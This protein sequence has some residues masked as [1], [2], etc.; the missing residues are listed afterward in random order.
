VAWIP[1]QIGGDTHGDELDKNAARAFF[2]FAKIW[3]PK[4]R[5]HLGDAFNLVAL[6]K[7]AGDDERRVSIA[8]DFEAGK[9]FLEEFQPTAFLLGNHDVRFHRIAEEDNGMLSDKATDCI[10]EIEA[11]CAKMKCRI[12]PYDV[13]DGVFELGQL[14]VIHGFHHGLH[15]ARQAALVYGAVLQGHVHAIQQYSLESR[16]N[17]I[18][19]SIGCLCNLRMKWLATKINSLRHR[20]GFAYGVYNDKSGLYHVYQAE[21]VDGKWILPTGLK[22]I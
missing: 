3:K 16:E 12:L 7:G 14:K 11:L 21:S 2:E 6:R 10:K 15:A 22:E 18:G 1:F 4:I 13:H 5:V 9:Q 19:R 20:H 8:S 17:R